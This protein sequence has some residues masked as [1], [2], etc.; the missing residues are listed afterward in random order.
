[1]TIHSIGLIGNPAKEEIGAAVDL[2]C[3]RC[4]ARQVDVR[5]TRRLA[6]KLGMRER[7]QEPRRMANQVDVVI[8]LG[9]DGTML[10]AARAI[11]MAGT[12][13]LGINLGSLGYLT[14]VPQDELPQALDR[15]LAGDYHLEER[16]R[17]HCEA[18]RGRKRLVHLSALNDIVVNMGPLPRALDLEIRLDEESLGRFL[19]DG[20]IV[21]SPTG[22]TAYN[23][24]AGGPICH[25]DVPC[26]LV[27]PICPHSLAIRP[28]IL[29]P[30]SEIELLLHEVGQGAALTAD[31]QKSQVLA[32]GDRLTFTLREGEVRLVKFP[33][34]NFFRVM[35]HKLNY[36]APERRRQG[37]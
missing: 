33:R 5:M 28:L 14:D 22:S 26:L 30:R 3:A 11:G 25:S 15:L 1:M 7:G 36:G 34:S 31:G 13:L 24:S 12:P 35:R 37:D 27:T 18:M 20:V 4:A 8:A 6:Q 23:L 19:G 29:S 2:V 10:K 9:G 16:A 32:N 17:V 21:S